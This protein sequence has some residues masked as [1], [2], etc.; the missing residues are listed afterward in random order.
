[1]PTDPAHFEVIR[2]LPER[3]R[4][5]EWTP[6]RMTLLKADDQGRP[7]QRADLPWLGSEVLVLRDQAIEPVG[8]LLQ[9]YGDV[10]PLQCEGARLAL[11]SAQAVAGVLDEEHSDMVRFSSGRIMALR[12][13]AFHTAALGDRQA[14]KLAEMPRGDLYITEQLVE[15]IRATG[16]TSGTDFIPV[17]VESH[18]R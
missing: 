11:F 9:S 8:G 6:I 10:L 1:M 14:F 5:S 7:H 15:A 12:S 4:A 16:M 3:P 13:P 18:R 2:R 17:D